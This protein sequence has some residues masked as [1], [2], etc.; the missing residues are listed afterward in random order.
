M[1]PPKLACCNFIPKVEHLR[2]FALD[3]G[4]QGVD[5]TIDRSS[6]PL[7]PAQEQELAAKIYRLQ[8]LEVRL[9]VALPGLD[10]GDDDPHQARLS[11]Q[12]FQQLCR[13]AARLRLH[14]LTIHLGLGRETTAS[15]E[16]ETALEQLQALVVFASRF[17]IRICLE[18]L[19]W[20]W[21]SRPDLYEKLLRKTGAWATFDL[22]HAQVCHAVT[23]TQYT[24][25]DFVLPQPE[26]IVNAHVYH[27]E[28]ER[29]HLPPNSLADLAPRLDLLR[30]LPLCDWWVLELHDEAALRQTLHIVQEYLHYQANRTD[31][32]GCPGILPLSAP[33]PSV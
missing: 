2:Q 6:L 10:L 25:A 28:D 31:L 1:W 20:G 9:H 3:L 27:L 16:W 24:V 30:S 33:D 15:L 23:S 26:R 32:P 17:W 29:G 11:A 12:V 4:L 13:L 21:T 7:D 22:G 19:A 14:Y 5:W 18:N 8:P